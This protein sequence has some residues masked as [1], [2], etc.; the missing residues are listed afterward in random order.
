MAAK[1]CGRQRARWLVK[2]RRVRG[3]GTEVWPELGRELGRIA[4]GRGGLYAGG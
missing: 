2:K 3:G 1:R 4:D